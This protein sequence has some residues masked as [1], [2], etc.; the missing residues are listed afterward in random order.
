MRVLSVW[1][2]GMDKP[3]DSGDA[4]IYFFPNGYTQESIIHLQDDDKRVISVKVSALTG[5]AT[6]VDGY[7]E[8]K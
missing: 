7:V 6:V 3:T 8:A 1:T 5:T 4:Y 2:E